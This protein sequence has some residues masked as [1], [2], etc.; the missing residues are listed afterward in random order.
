MRVSL[1]FCVVSLC[2]C[3]RKETPAPDLGVTRYCWVHELT[4]A[5][6]AEFST[7]F[8]FGGESAIDVH[9][10]GP[11]RVEVV[12][13]LPDGTQATPAVCTLAASVTAV[14]YGGALGRATVKG[15]FDRPCPPPP[16][17]HVVRIRGEF[18]EVLASDA[19]SPGLSC[20]LDGVVP[21]SV[22]GTGTDPADQ[23]A[24]LNRENAKKKAPAQFAAINAYLESLKRIGAA[25]ASVPTNPPRSTC[26]GVSGLVPIFGTY[27]L[28]YALV[29]VPGAIAV[30]QSEG[31]H[32][33]S[34]DSDFV[35]S[36]QRASG[37]DVA[38]VYELVDRVA[39]Q[40]NF[41]AV[42]V[43]RSEVLPQVST[44]PGKSD[45]TF[46]PG[47]WVGALY[48]F[49]RAGKVA[50]AT[51]L[52]VTSAG[53]K[54]TATT[55]SGQSIQDQIYADFYALGPAAAKAALPQIAPGAQ[56]N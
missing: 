43:Q 56:A 40:S 45:G 24:A 18:S 8:S 41:V 36:L 3:S 11:V 28:N 32:A 53:T 9:P 13:E 5:P 46:T 44:A 37:A 34:V 29:G 27:S 4:G 25:L 22:G 39:K 19:L 55:R 52:D 1:V 35:R 21:T 26:K 12:H 20:R 23:V 31:P 33:D 14:D 30:P 17:G 2:G 15:R 49:D 50:C 6:G 47:R 7:T 10:T 42:R 54:Y 16:A 51:P 38:K 48:V